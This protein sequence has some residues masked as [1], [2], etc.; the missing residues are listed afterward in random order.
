MGN[1]ARWS[2]QRPRR[3]RSIQARLVGVIGICAVAADYSF[4][5]DREQFD[6]LGAASS[7]VSATTGPANLIDGD[8]ISVKGERILDID[9]PESYQSA[10]TKSLC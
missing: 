8:T 6:I 10:A 4:L 9:A 1:E 5:V 2:A 3:G 7:I